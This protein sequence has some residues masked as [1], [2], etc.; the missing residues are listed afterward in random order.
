MKKSLLITALMLLAIVAVYANNIQVSGVSVSGQNVAAHFSMV[1][2][3]VTWDNSWRTSTNESN[4]D[5]AWIFIKFRKANSSLWQHATL[6][7]VV[8][9]SAAASGHT[10]PT[11]STLQQMADGKGIMIYRSANGAGTNTFNGASVRW[12]YGADNVQDNDS[13]EVR[14][15]AVEMVYVTQG[16]FYLGTGGIETGGFKIG[17]TTNPYLVTSEN[18]ITMGN[19]TNNLGYTV[20]G[21]TGDGTG[22]LAASWPK[23]FNAFWMM[24]YEA[25]EQQYVDFLNALDAAKANTRN[26]GFT[27]GANNY[28]STAPERA[29][30]GVNEI[31][32]LAFLDWAALRPFTELEYEKSCRGFNITP[33]ANEYAWGNTT[34][35][36]TSAVNNPGTASETPSNGNANYYPPGPYMGRALRNGAY[37]N[38]TTTTRTQTGGSYYG[39]M[40]LSGNCVEFAMS[41]GNVSGRSFTGLHGDGNLSATGTANVTNWDP[42]GV[43]LRGGSYSE[44]AV[45]LRVSERSNAAYNNGSGRSALYGIRGARTAE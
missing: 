37:A 30:T 11:G 2:F 40:E 42:A 5:G 27:G 14:V 24:K 10:Q 6:N 33:V 25:S 20:T 7:Y 43:G 34:I 44:P 36:Q 22:S 16:Q 28:T 31:D 13:V 15:Y 4:Y 35:L 9:G 29:L 45:T 8:P 19:T 18:A 39:A 1:N 12:N 32:H 41:A 17:A 38:D 3:S 26:T 23:G 21:S